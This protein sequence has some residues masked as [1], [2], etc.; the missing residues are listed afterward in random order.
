M[1]MVQV[2]ASMLQD[3]AGLYGAGMLAQKI[4]QDTGV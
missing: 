3:K 1:K 2:E 4:K